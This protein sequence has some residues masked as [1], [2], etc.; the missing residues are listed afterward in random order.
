MATT[1]FDD[2]IAAL[3]EAVIDAQ[4]LAE[5]QYKDFFDRYFEHREGSTELQAKKVDIAVRS[6]RPGEHPDAQ[7]VVQVPLICLAAPS[8]IKI[9]ELTV[10]F[11]TQLS[12][13]SASGAP[14]ER[15]IYVDIAAPTTGPDSRKS[16]T[17]KVT[18]SFQG[19]DPPE[20]VLRINDMMLKRL[21]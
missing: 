2:I 15:A 1:G 17:A 11:E 4:K 10:E 9:K 7:D 6:L 14:K 18:I 21:P 16:S 19:T 8:A 20:G 13:I 3:H 5:T 12:T